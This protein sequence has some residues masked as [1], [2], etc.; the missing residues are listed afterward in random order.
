MVFKKWRSRSDGLRVL[1]SGWGLV[2]DCVWVDMVRGLLHDLGVLWGVG[3]V[4]LPMIGQGVRL[5]G[6]GGVLVRGRRH[7]LPLHGG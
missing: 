2:Y 4:V 7:L 6:A 5:R 1:G 3:V